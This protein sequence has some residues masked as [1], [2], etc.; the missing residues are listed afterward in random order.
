MQPES[1]QHH[2]LG[3][4][5]ELYERGECEHTQACIHYSLLLAVKVTSCFS[6]SS[7][8]PCSDGLCPGIVIQGNYLLP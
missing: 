3:L 6:C 5:P 1:G 7:V 8:V 4:G 2:F